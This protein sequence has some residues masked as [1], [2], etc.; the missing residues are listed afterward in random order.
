[1]GTPESSSDPNWLYSCR[2]YDDYHAVVG[3]ANCPSFLRIETSS[4][5][6]Y[7]KP[8]CESC[9][10]DDGS[11]YETGCTPQ[12]FC[13]MMT[14]T[15]SHLESHDGITWQEPFTGVGGNPPWCAFTTFDIML[16]NKGPGYVNFVIT[17]DDTT[18]WKY[19]IKS[20]ATPTGK[21]S[22]VEHAHAVYDGPGAT[23]DGPSYAAPATCEA[24]P[25]GGGG[26]GDSGATP[27]GVYLMGNHH[28]GG[29][30]LTQFAPNTG[31]GTHCGSYDTLLGTQYSGAA[32]DRCNNVKEITW[33]CSEERVK[34]FSDVLVDY[35]NNDYTDTTMEGWLFDYDGVQTSFADRK[36]CTTADSGNFA[37]GVVNRLWGPDKGYNP[38][39]SWN[40]GPLEVQFMC[41]HPQWW[42]RWGSSTRNYK[43]NVIRIFSIGPGVAANNRFGLSMYGDT[44]LSFQ[45]PNNAGTIN[46][47]LIGVKGWRIHGPYGNAGQLCPTRAFPD[48]DGLTGPQNT[49]IGTFMGGGESFSILD[50]TVRIHLGGTSTDNLNF[51]MSPPGC[52]E[53]VVRW[54]AT[55]CYGFM[56][57]YGNR[58]QRANYVQLPLDTDANSGNWACMGTESGASQA[59]N[60][61][62]CSSWSNPAL[63]TDDHMQPQHMQGIITHFGFIK[64]INRM[65]MSPPP[66]PPVTPPPVMCVNRIDGT[67]NA[68]GTSQFDTPIPLTTT[69]SAYG[70][71]PGCYYDSGWRYEMPSPVYFHHE[72]A[73]VT[74]PTG[75]MTADI[76]PIIPTDGS[77]FAI[78]VT[79]ACTHE[80]VELTG[81]GTFYLF[82]MEFSTGEYL[83][84]S[85]KQTGQVYSGICIEY[86]NA[87]VGRSSSDVVG[88]ISNICNGQ[89]QTIRFVKEFSHGGKTE[90]VY[91]YWN[92]VRHDHGP[93]IQTNSGIT[94]FDRRQ[95]IISSTATLSHFCLGRDNG[96][97]ADDDFVGVIYSF[98]VGTGSTELMNGDTRC[99]S[100]GTDTTNHY[101]HL[102]CQQHN[103]VAHGPTNVPLRSDV[104][105]QTYN[106]ELWRR[107]SDGSVA[108]ELVCTAGTDVSLGITTPNAA[109]PR[110]WKS[111]VDEKVT[112][113]LDVN[114]GVCKI[115]GNTHP[116]DMPP[117]S[118]P[119]PSPPPPSPSPP[120]PLPSP[121]PPS[122]PPPSPSPPPPSPP[123]PASPPPSPLPLPP[124]PSPPPPGAP[125]ES[126]PPPPSP[127]PPLGPNLCSMYQF[128]EIPNVKQNVVGDPVTVA[129]NPGLD[130]NLEEQC[131]RT[132]LEC[133]QECQY[134]ADL[135]NGCQGFFY[136]PTGCTDGSGESTCIFQRVGT[137]NVDTVGVSANIVAQPAVLGFKLFRLA[138]RP[139]SAPPPSPP[140]LPP[141]AFTISVDGSD[142][143]PE[144]GV[145][146]DTPYTVTFTGDDGPQQ[147]DW[148]VWVRKD[149]DHLD[150]PSTGSECDGAGAIAAN[151]AAQLVAQ[152]HET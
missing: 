62:R 100:P 122:P 137:V 38:T 75:D 15:Y 42:P 111:V 146:H 116:V 85:V 105:G 31:S 121:P 114:A 27:S 123:P 95:A 28:A 82:D 141:P 46:Y 97:S 143:Q 6:Y 49:P 2:D 77:P 66:P 67:A 93:A 51:W 148:V 144:K 14:T 124:P 12:S 58:G 39:C 92:N 84:G 149:Y 104:S 53:D 86:N 139:P 107:N 3:N 87:G 151:D 131:G 102:G 142:P 45:L 71:V 135:K 34:A 1:M 40:W 25:S 64:P 4:Q 147:G 54:P 118:P 52:E 65:E 57:G 41:V 126:P 69:Y 132:E 5:N 125:P 145:L 109:A 91:V 17:S 16:I 20:D 138:D 74:C 48:H 130:E 89:V 110:Q 73:Q 60:S 23:C 113:E 32:G 129:E 8:R 80:T 134:L 127:P 61:P 152:Q 33:L 9:N 78:E 76:A 133:C 10:A 115:V 136:D 99:G 98:K 44:I 55:S 50:D 90:G 140:P 11:C 103:Y 18:R 29:C 24:I 81:D 88:D 30:D 26:G 22:M 112:I 35:F 150:D 43:A 63:Q 94:Y 37:S 56:N 47:D 117:P 83:R 108:D 72:V 19:M 101:A 70:N 128:T 13:N 120:P 68:A 79:F 106:F 119:P 59:G 36:S 21:G 7:V 96:G